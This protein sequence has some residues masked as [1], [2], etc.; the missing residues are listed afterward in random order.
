[1]RLIKENRILAL[2]LIAAVIVSGI[3]A[4]QRIS[5]ENNAKS[6]DIVVD[7][8]EMEL[9]SQQSENDVSW[10]LS[11]F[12]DMGITKVG[13]HE[14]TLKSLTESELPVKAELVKDLRKDTY[15]MNQASPEVLALIDENVKDDFDVLVIAGSK[16][17]YDF[18]NRAFEERYDPERSV[19]LETENGGYILI[20]GRVEDSLYYETE[21]ILMTEDTGFSQETDMAGSVIMYLNIGLLPEKVDTIQKAGCRVEPRTLGYAG[22]NDNRFLNDV[23]SSYENMNVVPD[24]WIMGSRAVPGY[25]DGT[26]K[27]TDYLNKNDITIGI[28]ENTTQRQNIS[29]DGMEDVITGTDYDVVR[30]FSVWPYIQYRYGYYGYE[31]YEEI[32][33]SLFRAVVERNVKVIYYKPMKETDDEYTYITDIQDYRDSFKNLEA[34]LAS[35]GIVIGEASTFEPYKV[36]LWAGIIIAIG[37]G[38]A[39]LFC[40]KTV[41]PVRNRCIYLLLAAGIL[42]VLG[43]Y[44]IA[45]GFSALLTSFAASVM[46]PCMTTVLMM[47]AAGEIKSRLDSEAGVV[48]LAVLGAAV[49]LGCVV[50]SAAGAVMT[51]APVSSIDYMLELDIFRGVK[52]AQLLPLAFFMLLFMLAALK[53]WGDK[54]KNTLEITDIKWAL[55][56]NI[57]MWMVLLA[58]VVGAAGFIYLARTGHESGIEASSLELLVRNYLEEVLYAR[59][60]TKEFLVAFPAVMLFIYSMVRNMKIFSFLF[61]LAGVIGFTSVTNTFMH[62]RTPMELGFARTGYAAVF[63]IVLG[64]MYILILEG[65][66]RIYRKRGSRNNA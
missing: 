28:V 58:M 15:W 56:Y 52:L 50:I 24:Y 12:A 23:T 43:A 59:P 55:N 19:S 7:Y 57:K 54:E 51:A 30:V 65:F 44:Y 45:P 26:E 27:L 9:L 47:Y 40:L 8:K 41:L 21:K 49:L 3:V 16:E 46:I 25:D 4:G 60:R 37:A 33:N 31:S 29:P 1:M 36:P 11:E 18:V 53:M 66:Y 17:M 42:G 61:G 6:V 22:W 10:W 38:C 63:G 14:E 64:I 62:I 13:L 32:E 48:K 5:V 34:R 35:H 20:D 2:I 39:A